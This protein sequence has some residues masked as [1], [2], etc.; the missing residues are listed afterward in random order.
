MA[1]MCRFLLL[2]LLLLPGARFLSSA[3]D[4][5]QGGGGGGGSKEDE[6]Y[7]YHGNNGLSDPYP[8]QDYRIAPGADAEYARLAPFIYDPRA[9]A[10]V[11][12][13]YAPWCPHVRFLNAFCG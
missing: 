10:R 12:E 13:F 5:Q 9:P 8:V 1:V 11:V 7:L 4:E 2:I 3:D 6:K